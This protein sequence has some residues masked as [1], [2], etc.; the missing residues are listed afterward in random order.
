MN[1]ENDSSENRTLTIDALLK[2]IP[3][4]VA[5]LSLLGRNADRNQPSQELKTESVFGPKKLKKTKSPTANDLM[6]AELA[7]NMEEVKGYTAR[8]WAAKIGKAKTTVLGT[9]TWKS[10]SMVRKQAK[11][12]RARDRHRR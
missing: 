9:E 2:T 5:R 7:A 11:A 3:E 6:K 8:Q 12:L 10:L 4:Q 1:A